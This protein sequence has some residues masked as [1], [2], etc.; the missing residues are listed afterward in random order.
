MIC[1][2]KHSISYSHTDYDM[3]SGRYSTWTE[4]TWNALSARIFLQ[5]SATH[6]ALTLAI[7]FVVTTISFVL[8]F[9]VNSRADVL[10]NIGSASS[11]SRSSNS[12]VASSSLAASAASAVVTNA[13]AQC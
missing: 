5:P 8:V 9:L 6:E 3:K 4:S 10:F 7:G 11:S 1:T 13:P 2:P 12:A